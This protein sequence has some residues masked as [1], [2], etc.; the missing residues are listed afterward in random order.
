MNKLKIRREPV[1][2]SFLILISVTLRLPYVR[3]G[4]PP[5]LSC[6]EGFFANDVFRMI[7]EPSVFMKEFRSGSMNSW[8]MLI[9]AMFMY[10]SENLSYTNLIIVGRF[11]LPI[12]VA[13]LTIIPMYKIMK[14]VNISNRSAYLASLLFAISPVVISQAEMWYPDSYVMFVSALFILEYLKCKDLSPKQISRN[15]RLIL[16]FAVGVSVKHNFAFFFF[17]IILFELI[18][19]TQPNSTFG[20]KVVLIRRLFLNYK[21]FMITSVLIFFILNYSILFDFMNFLRALNGN[22]KIYAITDLNFIP[23]FFFYTYNLLVSPVGLVGLGILI[24]GVMS[25]LKQDRKLA[26]TFIAFILLFLIIA[27]FPKQALA[28]NIN[29]LLPLTFLF[30]GVGLDSIRK[31]KNKWLVLVIFSLLGASIGIA[32]IKF[33]SNQLKNDSYITTQKWFADNLSGEVVGVN[34]GCN[35]PSPAFIGGASVRNVTDT[36]GNLDYYLF[37]SFGTGPFFD[38]F[39]QQNVYASGNPRYL[40]YYSFN[41]TRIFQGWTISNSLDE[42]VPDGYSIKKVFEGSGPTFILL[43]RIS[44]SKE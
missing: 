15:K 32:Q 19:K 18:S 41:D 9:P 1:I 12:F 2:L 29:I 23:G 30:M 16:I 17:L 4:L 34:N 33:Q 37:S 8:P 40:N 11:L 35:G 38:Y 3:Q 21:K 31:L 44:K 6:D 7:F 22:R 25:F 39:R 14:L 43:E 20:S 24:V 28:R 5:Y 42:Y 10:L 13:S 36:S 27:G 26:K